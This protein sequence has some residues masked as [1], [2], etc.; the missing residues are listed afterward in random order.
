MGL[1]LSFWVAGFFGVEEIFDRWRGTKDFV[2]TTIASLAMAG[3]M[4]AYSM[5]IVLRVVVQ[6][7]LIISRSISDN[8]S[9]TNSKDR[10]SHRPLY[11]SSTRR[12]ISRKR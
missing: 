3:A 7:R 6:M 2:N 4:S 8:Y 10:T 9:G 12:I 11:R 5:C 1:R